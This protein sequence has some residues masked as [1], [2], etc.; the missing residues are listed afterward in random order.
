MK[1]KKVLVTGGS[2]F[3]G[4]NL[5]ERLLDLG[6]DIL[7][8]DLFPPKNPRHKAIF[9]FVD[10]KD[11]D[12]LKEVF[13]KFEPNWVIHL[14]ARTDLN[15]CSLDEY[16]DNTIATMNLCKRLAVSGSVE[17][18][19]FASSMLVCAAGHI[20][21]TPFEYSPNTVYGESKV[22]MER[23]IQQY[24]GRFGFSWSIVRPTSIWGPWF[25]EPYRNFFTRVLSERYFRIGDRAAKKTYGYVGNAVNQILSILENREDRRSNIKYLGDPQ[26]MSADEWADSICRC[27]GYREPKKL[28]WF[29]V[30]AGSLVGDLL[31]L[32]G[33][34]FPL[35]TFRLK[36]MTTENII[37]PHLLVENK[38]PT[39]DLCMAIKE[40]ITWLKEQ[41]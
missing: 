35:T 2:G 25:G 21:N 26:P 32:F 22:E 34:R 20:P 19:I 13:E 40:T 30:K 39:V 33:I 12:S 17:S 16:R 23:I 3:I 41:K 31:L 37:P 29:L 15:G 18:V 28:P 4:T 27:V 8:V 6:L 1:N 36:N 7:S 11:I 10:L 14:A 24:A 9:R 38:Y 5:V